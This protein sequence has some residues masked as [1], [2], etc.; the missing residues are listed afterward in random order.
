MQQARTI[1]EQILYR[2]ALVVQLRE[3]AEAL[4]SC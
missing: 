4:L 2:R 3:L 1:D